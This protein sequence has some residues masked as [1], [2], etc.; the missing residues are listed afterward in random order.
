MVC[1]R[2]F[3]M[4]M[5]KRQLLWWFLTFSLAIFVM[6]ICINQTFLLG[7]TIASALF[8]MNDLSVQCWFQS[9]MMY[10][11]CKDKV[12]FAIVF[13]NIPIM[14]ALTA[15]DDIFF[16]RCLKSLVGLAP[17]INLSVSFSSPSDSSLAE[18]LMFMALCA[19]CLVSCTYC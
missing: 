14:L 7:R 16:L 18:K 3:I 12:G 5:S 9:N 19:I 8:L 2:V 15:G 1:L 11:C 10:V 17:W 13:L 6:M 4:H